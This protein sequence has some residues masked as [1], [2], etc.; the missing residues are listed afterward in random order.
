MDTSLNA[1][2]DSLREYIAGMA[3]DTLKFAVDPNAYN[4]ALA[5]LMNTK[6][7]R[8]VSEVDG[9]RQNY[10]GTGSKAHRR[11]LYVKIPTHSRGGPDVWLDSGY[12]R[13]GGVISIP[14]SIP[15]ERKYGDDAPE[16]VYGWIRDTLKQIIDWE[17][18][19]LGT[20]KSLPMESLMTPETNQKLEA[21]RVQLEAHIKAPEVLGISTLGGGSLPTMPAGAKNKMG[22][23][24]VKTTGSQSAAPAKK[25]K[26][27]ILPSK[28]GESIEMNSF[29]RL[30]GLTTPHTNLALPKKK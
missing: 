7:K 26:D 14:K 22:M 9:V 15:A 8:E 20:P 16:T 21:L 12:V 28:M 10:K 30:A 24:V 6:L 23:Q 5:K 17:S 13:I 4:T 29:R 19:Q 1:K 27:S 2:L 3:E 25:V 18:T 11:Q